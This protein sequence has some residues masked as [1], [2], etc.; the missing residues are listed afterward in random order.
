MRGAERGAVHGASFPQK[1]LVICQ[2]ALSLVL[3]AGA[4]LLAQSLRNLEHQRFGFDTDH[5]Y[6]VQLGEA[7]TDFPVEK[8]PGTY[9]ELQSRLNA[10]PGVITA[11]YSI[12]SPMGGDNWSGP[13]YVH[14]R[15]PYMGE[16]GDFASWLRV[17]PNYFETIGTGLLRGRTIGEQD[18]PTSTHVAVVN[19]RFA[20]KFFPG[21][22]PIGKHFGAHDSNHRSDW[23]IVGVVEDA[24]YQ[25]THGPAYA[26]Y[27]L[28]YFQAPPTAHPENQAMVIASNWLRSIE[29]HVAGNPENLESTVRNILAQSDPDATVVRMTSFGEQVSQQMNL[30]RLTA[31]LTLLFG[32]LALTL[33]T[34]GLYGVTAYTVE[35]RTREIGVR[36]AVGANRVDVIA[37]VLRGAFRQ[38]AIGLV[39]GLVLAFAAGRLLES[40][41]FE[42]KG[43]SPLALGGATLMLAFFAFLAG[44]IP[45]RRAASINPVA[46]LRVE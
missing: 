32:I 45:A 5:R 35:R 21:Q 38:V 30:E 25:D 6:V 29:L 10:I 39:I 8:L 23:E 26:T 3:V 15:T 40:Q 33:A 42:V 43:Y 18:T 46:A 14:G 20:K 7:F 12:Y 16:H 31:R 37:M 34:V 13:V 36:V 27:F 24:K 28:P 22:D 2:A 41:L 19:E 17:S 44:L 1:L 4:I 11:S 9:R